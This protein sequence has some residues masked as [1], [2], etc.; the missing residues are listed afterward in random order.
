MN[1]LQ[2]FRLNWPTPNTPSATLSHKVTAA[3]WTTKLPLCGASC[4]SMAG[5]SWQ[6]QRARL[7]AGDGV[8]DGPLECRWPFEDEVGPPAFQRR[9]RRPTSTSHSTRH[10]PTECR[11]CAGAIFVKR[12]CYVVYAASTV[13]NETSTLTKTLRTMR[14]C[15]AL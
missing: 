6:V 15:F 2:K 3:V 5:A 4:W 7:A 8:N 12:S 13:Y 9:S 14:V 11:R 1:K 10:L